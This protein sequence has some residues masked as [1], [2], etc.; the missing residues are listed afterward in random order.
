MLPP[1]ARR[2]SLASSLASGLAVLAAAIVVTASTGCGIPVSEQAVPTACP[3][4][5][6]EPNDS[7]E[8]AEDLGE[9]S[10]EP[11]SGR[12]ITSSVHTSIDRDWYRV[13]VAD[14]GL[15]G[16]PEVSVLVSSGFEVTTWFVCGDRHTATSECSHGSS[17]Y[18]RVGGVEGCRGNA[19]EGPSGEIDVSADTMASST[20]DCSGTSSDDGDLYIR[21]ERTASAGSV[22]TYD[23]SIRVK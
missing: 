16:N 12:V 10:D 7:E 23:L 6:N 8:T 1:T 11:S 22:C 9:L 5:S 21:V 17:D 4:A 13:H 14:R 18:A 20:T 15:G 19:L 3:A 2:F